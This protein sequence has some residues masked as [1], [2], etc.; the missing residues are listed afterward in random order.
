[1]QLVLRD[2]QSVISV[3]DLVFKI[4]FNQSLIHQI[5]T[6][7]SNRARQGSRA[8]KNRSEV[9]GSGKKPWRQKGTGR[10]R[11]GS[12]RSP[13]WR[14]GGVT[15]AAKPKVY[16]HKVNRKMYRGALR[17][18]FSQL[19]RQNRLIVFK[20][21]SI[22]SFKTKLLIQKLQSLKLKEVLIITEII[23]KNLLFASRNLYKVCVR[24]VWSVDPI[25]L[26]NFKN[27]IMTFDAIKKVEEILI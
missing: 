10:A 22:S 25:S 23:N 6:S 5:V 17:S 1:M 4:D 14:S 11:V 26:V 20:D 2:T 15:F 8:Q 3:S 7:Y 9:S 19:I 18:I 21:F 16:Y 12:I 24:D 27:T 13:I